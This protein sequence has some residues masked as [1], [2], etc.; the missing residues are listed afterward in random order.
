MLKTGS[1]LPQCSPTCTPRVGR[2]NRTASWL[3]V[4]SGLLVLGLG[5]RNQPS[6]PASTPKAPPAVVHL[7]DLMR[8]RLLLM[9]EV[10]R[11]KWNTSKPIADP[12]REQA[13]L[14][15]V[16]QNGSKYDLDPAHV[17]AFFTAQ[18]E[19][20]KL[21][22]QA[23]F[24]AW[25]VAGQGPF[26]QALDLTSVLRPRIDELSSALLAA[27]AEARPLLGQD[28]MRESLR[29]QAA[30]TLTG[31][32]IDHTIRAAAVA[33]LLGQAGQ[34]DLQSRSNSQ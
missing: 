14:D 9:H 26:P 23:D 32:G 17:R 27:L 6:Q 10:A 31:E 1:S 22:Q 30:T 7:L 21:L 13:F 8:Q 33:P 19:A 15:Q 25:Q 24:R 16:A 2:A 12:A 34:P 4:A 20:A 11:W 28:H 18:I 29:E 3:I 5:C